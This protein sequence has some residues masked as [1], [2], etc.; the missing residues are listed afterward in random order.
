MADQITGFEIFDLSNPTMPTL[1]SSTNFGGLASDVVVSAST[2]GVFAYLSAYGTLYVVDVSQPVTPV[3]RGQTSMSGVGSIAIMGHYV[4]GGSLSDGSIHMVDVSNPTAP[5]DSQPSAGGYG[6]C[7]PVSVA[8]ANNYLYVQSWFYGFLV[9]NVSG[10]NLT[11]IGQNQ[12]V[13]SDSGLDNKMILSGNQAYIAAGTLGLQIVDVSNPY[14][15]AALGSFNDSQ[16]YAQPFYV[17]V[18]GN[19]LCTANGNIRIFDASQPGTLTPVSSPI[20]IGASRV[21]AGNGLA[22]V[23]A[24][25]GTRIYSLATPS[26]PQLKAT[27]SNSVVYARDLQLSGTML[28]SAGYVGASIP[29]FVAT[30]VSNPSSPAVRGT[31]NFSDTSAIA[32]CLAINGNKALIG[33]QGNN[34]NRISCVDI[35]NV[36]S[37]V[38][39]GSLNTTNDWPRGIRISPDG[40][41]AYFIQFEYPS[42]VHV[43]NINNLASPMAVAN[44]PLDSAVSVAIELR[45]NELY[46]ATG[47]GLYVFDISNPALPTLIRS[48]LMSTIYGNGGICA[49]TDSAGQSANIYVADSSGGIVALQEQDIQAPDVYITDPIFRQH[50]DDHHV[51]H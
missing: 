16:L 46:V 18:T 32:S 2:N 12:N 36:G 44:I 49:P 30:D 17:A 42:F 31:K 39:R 45:G 23:Q 43:V 51:Q 48:Y 8:A 9:F 22:Y 34:S 10:G 11:F 29:C 21:V 15:P 4:F 27:I 41:Y 13:S 1:L 33:I 19:S 5:V 14:S 37:P 25:D 47:N 35:S 26:S 7:E 24:Q 6:T 50:M 3:L 20:A 38:E 40:N 28:Y